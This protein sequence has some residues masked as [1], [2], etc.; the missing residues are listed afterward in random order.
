MAELVLQCTAPRDMADDEQQ[1]LVSPGTL[2]APN[3]ASS[4]VCVAW[5]RLPSL[6]SRPWH[7]WNRP[8]LTRHVHHV[9][10]DG[11]VVFAHWC[12]AQALNWVFGGSTD[13]PGSIVNLSDGYSERL[14]YLAAHTAV[15][16]DKRV[17]RQVFLQVRMRCRGPAGRT[18]A[19]KQAPPACLCPA[20]RGT[21]RGATPATPATLGRRWGTSS[22]ACVGGL[23]C[24]VLHVSVGGDGTGTRRS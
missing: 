9:C 15:I 17:R 13:V 6:S 21:C 23:G 7:A 2:P 8:P 3:D 10:T 4:A 18:G 1:A 11:G 19:G 16:F 5:P 12:G 20:V 24:H 14:C 22:G